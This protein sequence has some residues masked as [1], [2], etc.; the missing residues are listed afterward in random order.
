MPPQEI[1]ATAFV[2]H[3]ADE[4]V[5]LLTGA[6]SAAILEAHCTPELLRTVKCAGHGLRLDAACNMCG[7]P[8]VCFAM[9][10]APTPA[11]MAAQFAAECAARGAPRF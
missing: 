4:A 8:G 9:K 1:G 6:Q 2:G 3:T 5:V 10:A 11:E 7:G